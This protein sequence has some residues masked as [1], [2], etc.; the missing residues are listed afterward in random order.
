[1][2]HV[3]C[4]LTRFFFSGAG[5][6]G[7]ELASAIAQKKFDSPYPNKEIV[8]IEALDRIVSRGSDKQRQ[9][10]EKHLKN[11]G[12]TIK[13]N[14]RVNANG[15]LEYRSSEGV[16][17]SSQE[18]LILTATGSKVN[19]SFLKNSTNDPSLEFCLDRNDRIRVKDTLQVDHWKYQHIF[20]GGDATNVVEEKTAYAATLAGV[21]I[22][23]NI[24]RLEKGKCAIPQGTKGL[25]P[26]PSKTLH[27]KKSQGGVGKGKSL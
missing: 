4:H 11:L 2:T 15:A 7:C 25:L 27:G 17:Y 18:Y 5:L 23:R 10:I 24:C 1:M 22:A 6:V 21:C 14:E 26:P 9:R 3:T 19:S 8:M 20:A 13:L 12:V 16:T